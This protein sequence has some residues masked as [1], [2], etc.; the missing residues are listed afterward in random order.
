MTTDK[1]PERLI[2]THLDKVFW[3][4]EGYRKHDLIEYYRKISNWLLPYLKDRPVVL[5]RFPDGIE[6]KSFYQK[7]APNFVPNWMH[8]EQ[9]W[10]ESS[11]RDI[12][13]FVI[14]DLDSLLYVVNLGSIPIHCWLSRTPHLE[15]P[16]WCVI[17][18]DPKQAPFKHVIT[19]ARAIHDLCNTI[20]APN[21]IKTTGSTGAHVLLPLGARYTYEQSRT[22]AERFAGIIAQKLPDIATLVRDPAKRGGKVYVDFLQ[23]GYGQTI[24]APF[25][26]RPRPGA[27]VSMPIAWR[28][29]NNKLSNQRFTIKNTMSR[30][31]RQKSDPWDG[32]TSAR[33]DLEQAL[34]C[35]VHQSA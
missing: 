20:G 28:E 26:V 25:C 7:N 9:I 23:N 16:D 6:G 15:Y 24:A 10:S 5:R 21:F 19:I 14:D 2:L 31:K 30:L 27:P 11:E 32:L 3:P 4:Q 17:D 12:G 22:L 18:I 1:H 13:Y 8:I 33:V 34:D 35:L 29:V